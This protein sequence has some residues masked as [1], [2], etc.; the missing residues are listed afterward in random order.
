M[1]REDEVDLLARRAFS[2][3]SHIINGAPDMGIAL[4]AVAKLSRWMQAELDSALLA[5]NKTLA[6]IVIN[7]DDE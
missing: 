1:K 7:G 6:N 2:A 5:S 4:S 3:A